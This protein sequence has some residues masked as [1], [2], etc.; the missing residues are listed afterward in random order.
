[1]EKCDVCNGMEISTPAIYD[2]KIPNGPWAFLCGEHFITLG[3]KLGLSHGQIMEDWQLRI[4]DE[5]KEVSDRL[6]KLDRFL[7]S[8][9]SFKMDLTDRYLLIKQSVVMAEYVNI[10]D[11]R[12]HRFKK[13]TNNES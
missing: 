10:L 1:M 6:A 7:D 4:L 9:F 2:A 12:I 13:G 5:R 8:E 11:K 3:C